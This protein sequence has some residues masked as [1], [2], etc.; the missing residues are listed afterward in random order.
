MVD[1][2]GVDIFIAA[3]GVLSWIGAIIY[4]ATGSIDHL[5]I[6][7]VLDFIGLILYL[8]TLGIVICSGMLAKYGLDLVY[9]AYAVA[10]SYLSLVPAYF[11]KRGRAL[12]PR[13]SA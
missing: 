10:A 9:G 5:I 4:G 8:S 11:F 3:I 13:S 7:I 12:G 1:V 2:V 6:S